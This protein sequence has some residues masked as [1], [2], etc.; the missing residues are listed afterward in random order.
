M[1]DKLV[2]ELTVAIPLSGTEEDGY[3]LAR[4]QL[5]RRPKV[6]DG[7]HVTIGRLWSL[8]VNINN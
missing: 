8:N 1:Y 7:P 2:F 5:C 3:E 4:G 6:I